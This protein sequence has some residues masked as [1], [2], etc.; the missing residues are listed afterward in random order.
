MKKVLCFLLLISTLFSHRML[1]QV[2]MLVAVEEYSA[3]VAFYDL[4]KHT[5]IAEVNVGFKPHEVAVDKETM[6]CFV[7]N[8]GL[9]DYYNRDGVP[10][11]TISVIDMR[12]FKEVTRICTSPDSVHDKAPHGIKIRPVKRELFTNTEAEDV[13]LVYDLKTLKL[14]RKFSIPNGTHNF[15]FTPEG[16]SLWVMAGKNGIYHL[17]PETGAV[18]Q[19]ITLPSP[20]RGL[21]IHDHKIVASLINEVQIIN[22]YKPAS[23]VRI[24][25]LGVGQVIY[26]GITRDGKYIFAPN[27]NDSAV[28]ALDVQKRAV[29]KKFIT[30]HSPTNVVTHKGLAYVSNT[31]DDHISIID[32]A[33][34]KIIG[35]MPSKGPNGLEILE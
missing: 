34:M 35:T 11:K 30:G 16:D 9:E 7:T 29:I 18:R 20:I 13:M 25:K 17:N 27:P 21:I 12:S 3:Q 10:G 24:E 32:I 1:A 4:I 15:R 28:V 19:H 8:F 6:R 23:P 33:S 2:P 31:E 22:P 5:K 26:S 14:K